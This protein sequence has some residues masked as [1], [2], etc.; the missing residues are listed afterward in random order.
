MIVAN[1]IDIPEIRALVATFISRP[2]AVSCSLVCKA[3]SQ[4]FIARIWHSVDLYCEEEFEAMDPNVVS[5]HGHH[6]RELNFHSRVENSNLGHSSVQNVSKLLMVLSSQPNVRS[7]AIDFL[8]QNRNAIKEL[9]I[10]DC[11]SSI[12]GSCLNFADALIPRTPPYVSNLTDLSLSY[13]QMTRESFS[14]LISACPQL[15]YVRLFG[16]IFRQSFITKPIKNYHVTHIETSFTQI[17]SEPS[18]SSILEHF[19]NLRSWKVDTSRT[20][21][22]ID[23]DAI[24]DDLMKYCPSLD[25][26]DLQSLSVAV[27]IKLMTKISGPLTSVS[28]NGRILKQDVILGLLFHKDSLKHVHARPYNHPFIDYIDEDLRGMGEIR[29]ESELS[30]TLQILTMNCPNL[31]KIILPELEAEMKHI[32]RFPWICKNLSHLAIRIDGL[33]TKDSILEVIEIWRKARLARRKKDLIEL[34]AIIKKCDS[35]SIKDR[36]AR[37]LLQFE[38][39]DTLWLG[40]KT[41]RA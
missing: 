26:I 8:R 5:K 17:Q 25:T 23:V 16:C 7:W 37:H 14:E 3:W 4:E 41:W 27:A 38:K 29:I 36:V 20:V 1:P 10:V 30:W 31:E 18:S 12:H 9:R 19:P 2:D 35:M 15:T 24:L 32:E 21:L 28:F 22:P 13:I 39:L 11:A 33:K 40:Y 6:I 34:D